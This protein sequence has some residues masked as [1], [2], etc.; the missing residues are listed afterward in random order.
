M[1]KI[2]TAVYAL[3]AWLLRQQWFTSTVLPSIPRPARWLLRR[4][5][6]LP[7]DLI[8]RMLGHREEMFPPKSEIFTG[9][10]DDFKRSGQ[11]LVRRLVD[12]AGLTPDSTV[13]DVGAGMG[14]LA[15]ALT[16][17]LKGGGC[18]EGMEIVPS[19]IKWC[20]D[21]ITSRFPNF[22]FT[23]AD[24]YNKEYNPNG[25]IKA[26]EYRFP[27]EDG[28][29]DLVQLTSVFTHMLPADIE[30]YI[31]EISRVLKEDGRCYVTYNLIDE[32]S[33]KS[34]E[35]GHSTLRLKHY[36]GPCW[37]V[38]AKVPELAVGYDESYVRDLYERYAL[39]SDYTIYYG[40]WSGRPLLPGKEPTYDQDIIVSANPRGSA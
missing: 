33:L 21:N 30:H 35:A 6:F 2:E 32:E 26:T 22:R 34:M 31:A 13:L 23:L 3:R 24:I 18:Y 11:A 29:F 19:G 16:P 9:S 40:S 7:S 25:R 17:Y 10:V 4:L 36:V 38:D 15:V 37:V 5:Y 39:A 14:R 1:T 12:L 20:N 27:Y 28:T 8:D